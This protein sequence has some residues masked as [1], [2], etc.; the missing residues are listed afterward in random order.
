MTTTSTGK[1][2]RA[3]TAQERRVAEPLPPAIGVEVL[4]ES[5]GIIQVGVLAFPDEDDT[6]SDTSCEHVDE[7]VKRSRK[8]SKKAKKAGRRIRTMLSLGQLKMTWLNSPP[9]SEKGE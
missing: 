7:S 3:V 5:G 8:T 2:G 4:D 9:R 1:A 6:V